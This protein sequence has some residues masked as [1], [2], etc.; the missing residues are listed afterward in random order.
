MFIITI[1]LL[2][3]TLGYLLVLRCDCIFSFL[4]PQSTLII[5]IA[6]LSCT[7]R[8][9]PC[10]L[11]TSAGP[12]SLVPASSTELTRSSCTRLQMTPTWSLPLT[13]HPLSRTTPCLWMQATRKRIVCFRGAFCCSSLVWRQTLRMCTGWPSKVT[14]GL[15]MMCITEASER[16]AIV[17]AKKDPC[18]HGFVVV[19]SVCL[20][21]VDFLF[22]C[23]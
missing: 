11:C 6:L 20:A 7:L 13:T 17:S 5:T 18:C 9:P 4:S 3:C 8:I 14:S 22:C 23:C 12:S 2:S 1:T 10:T 16:Q 15:S 19:V 21:V